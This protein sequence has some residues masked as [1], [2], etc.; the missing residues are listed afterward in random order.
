MGREKDLYI[1]KKVLIKENSLKKKYQ[2]TCKS[3]LRDRP[4]SIWEII[5]NGLFSDEANHKTM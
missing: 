3:Q 4:K 5:H 1:K 2:A